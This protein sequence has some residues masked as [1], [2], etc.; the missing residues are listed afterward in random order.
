MHCIPSISRNTQVKVGRGFVKEGRC[1]EKKHKNKNHAR[2]TPRDFFQNHQGRAV[3]P[4]SGHK[5][6]TV[7]YKLWGFTELLS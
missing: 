4:Q 3:M 1:H 7:C 2:L 5:L 6:M